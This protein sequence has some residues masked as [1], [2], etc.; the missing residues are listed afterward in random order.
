MALLDISLPGRSFE[1]KGALLSQQTVGLV[2]VP[3]QSFSV[4][5]SSSPQVF[6]ENARVLLPDP[7]EA[8]SGLRLLALRGPLVQPDRGSGLRVCDREFGV[9]VGHQWGG[10]G[11]GQLLQRG[12]PPRAPGRHDEHLEAKLPSLR[13]QGGGGGG[14]GDAIQAGVGEIEADLLAFPDVFLP[15]RERERTRQQPGAARA[16]QQG[17]PIPGPLQQ[18][19]LLGY[20]IHPRK[21]TP[22]RHLS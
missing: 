17:G 18:L 20:D 22:K 19:G 11:T 2:C 8:K 16:S 4:A 21:G 10:G 14:G 1:H 6:L 12:G 15:E 9:L 3:L 7:A 13:V 5:Q